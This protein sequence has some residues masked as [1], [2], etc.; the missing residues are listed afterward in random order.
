MPTKPKKKNLTLD[1]FA[2]AIQQDYL[3]LVAKMD[4]G[5]KKMRGE[6][7]TNEELDAGF[8]AIRN[9]MATHKAL[10]EV[11]DDVKRLNG[12][13]VSK[14][15]LEETIQRKLDTSPF[16]NERDLTDLRLRVRRI[17]GKLGMKP[18]RSAA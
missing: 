17:E 14:A 8:R 12:I 15:D 2:A 1:D 13:M 18:S 6:M 4:D 7:A 5:F 11:H 3:A 16:A 10:L 9:D